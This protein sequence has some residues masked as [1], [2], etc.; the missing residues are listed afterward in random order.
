MALYNLIVN[1]EWAHT[2][3]F[4]CGDFQCFWRAFST[5]YPSLCFFL[6]P[7]TPVASFLVYVTILTYLNTQRYLRI[8]T[9]LPK[10]T[11]M[12]YVTPENAAGQ[13]SVCFGRVLR[14]FPL[15]GYTLCVIDTLTSMALPTNQRGVLMSPE[16]QT[17]C[18]INLLD[19][20]KQ[21]LLVLGQ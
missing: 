9:N 17:L 19:G 18:S 21:S 20:L 7:P 4:H 15:I 11:T 3:L 1:F 14:V 5:S 16:F 10:G 12:C 13:R 2:A 6:Y 8:E